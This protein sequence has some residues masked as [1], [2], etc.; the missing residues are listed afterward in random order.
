[1]G[2]AGG[3]G[4]AGERKGAGGKTGAENHENGRF[5]CFLKGFWP[6]EASRGI[7]GPVATFSESFRPYGGRTALFRPDLM[8]SGPGFSCSGSP[9]QALKLPARPSTPETCLMRLHEVS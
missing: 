6:F 8:F 9:K 5:R 7:L 1:M 4:W 2:W 3:M